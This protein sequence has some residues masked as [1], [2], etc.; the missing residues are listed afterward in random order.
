MSDPVT[1][2]RRVCAYLRRHPHA[3]ANEV[4]SA[5]GGAR[6]Q[7]LLNVVRFAQAVMEG[8]RSTRRAAAPG[9]HLSGRGNRPL[10][11]GIDPDAEYERVRDKFSDMDL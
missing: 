7:H 6:R 9:N 8:S 10:A 4:A 1:L 11:D 5:V 2:F 3:S